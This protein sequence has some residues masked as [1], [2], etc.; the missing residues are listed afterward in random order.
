[1]TPEQRAMIE[2][3]ESILLA[4]SVIYPHYRDACLAGAR[5]LRATIAAS[6]VGGEVTITRCLFSSP[7]PPPHASWADW[8]REVLRTG[9]FTGVA[10]KA[11][12]G[13]LASPVGGEAERASTNV[14]DVSGELVEAPYCPTHGA[15]AP[16]D[17]MGRRW[18]CVPSCSLVVIVE[19]AALASPAPAPEPHHDPP[20]G[21]C[22]WLDEG[23]DYTTECGHG[24]QFMDGGVEQND[25]KFC[26]FCGGR[27]TLVPLPEVPDER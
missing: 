7:P 2:G 25:A 17:E 27:I 9:L 5:A 16:A 22:Q 1:M 21:L 12:D 8:F 24:W 6:P 18:H 3:D 20:M 19:R 26:P 10:L 13:S 11:W 14:D 15:M 4:M 23:S